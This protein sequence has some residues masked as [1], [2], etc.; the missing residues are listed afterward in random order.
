V[1]ARYGLL[2]TE[3]MRRR[4]KGDGRVDILMTHPSPYIQGT[5]PKSYWARQVMAL[6]EDAKR[7]TELRRRVEVCRQAA[8]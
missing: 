4:G 7:L 1:N 6:P 8:R 2:N 5:G 3:H